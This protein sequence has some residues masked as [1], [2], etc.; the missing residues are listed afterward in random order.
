MGGQYRAEEVKARV[1]LTIDS[2]VFIHEYH[3]DKSIRAA[4]SSP[5]LL[6]FGFLYHAHPNRSRKDKEIEP[7]RTEVAITLGRPEKKQKVRVQLY[8]FFH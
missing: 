3:G 6:L 8:T 1:G 2:R 5:S 7:V 4:S